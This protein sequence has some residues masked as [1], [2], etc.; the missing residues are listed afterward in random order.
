MNLNGTFSPPG[1]KS[2]SHRLAL[3]SL[4]AAGECLAA[5]L[6]PGAD[7]K[8]SL[9][10]ARVLGSDWQNQGG[11]ILIKG[12]AGRLVP[13]AE[14]D[15][16]NSGT[17]MRLLM[18]LLAGHQG[19]YVLD[20]DESLRKRPMER[21]A[22]PLRLMGADILCPDGRC[23]VTIRGGGL[24][25]LDYE[26][27]VASAQLKSAVLL[28]GLQARGR[29]M[30][31]EKIP[32][33]D[34]TEKMIASFGGSISGDAKGWLV[35][36]SDLHLSPTMYVPGDPSSAAFFLCAAAVLPGS[37]VTAEG[38]MLNPTRTGFLNVLVRMGAQVEIETVSEHPEPWGRVTC[39]YSPELSGCTV[40]AKEIPTLVDEVP[41]LALIA[42]QARGATTFKQVGELRVKE[43]DRL[44]AMAQG[45]TR[46]GAQAQVKGDDLIVQ[47][48]T[49]LSA[50]PEMDS[51]GDHRLAMTFRLAGVLAGA[52]FP[53]HHEDCVQISYPLFLQDL[54]RLLQ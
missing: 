28:A 9:E 7:V 21:I 25:G 33:R 23:P 51:L 5:N 14:L 45:L 15:C 8:S 10:A 26:L 4:L 30:V 12:A 32:S 13:K 6:A 50:T 41:I 52:R 39:T 24:H 3:M 19:E 20:G 18:G 35:Q 17:T 40:E 1:D 43:A 31:R 27:P 42:T 37:R 38:I 46:L 36:P 2:I 22:T 11:Q 47:G 54:D 34:H 44:T 53:I 29:T 49:P 16:G 48:P